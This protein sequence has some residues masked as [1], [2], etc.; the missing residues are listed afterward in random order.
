MLGSD[1]TFFWSPDFCFTVHLD[2]FFFVAFG[3][4]ASPPPLVAATAPSISSTSLFATS[5]I[6]SSASPPLLA[7]AIALLPSFAAL[8]TAVPSVH[9]DAFTAAPPAC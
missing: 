3:A 6:S 1:C 8:P 5:P 4:L 9:S 7:A 2:L